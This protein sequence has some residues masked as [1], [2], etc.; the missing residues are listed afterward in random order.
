METEDILNI[1]RKGKGKG[2][3]KAKEATNRK[4]P[5]RETDEYGNV[6]GTMSGA[7]NAC[8]KKGATFKEIVETL[9]KD[10]SKE[11]KAASGKVTGH[12]KYL[13]AKGFK[14]SEKEGVFKFD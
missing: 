7:V 4:A 2:K 9:K 5:V 12:I 10:F 8:L 14:V 3:G 6:V 1:I 11:E 13:K